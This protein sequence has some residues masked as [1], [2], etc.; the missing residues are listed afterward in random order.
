MFAE[1]EDEQG[2]VNEDERDDGLE[3]VVEQAD[4]EPNTE[5]QRLVKKLHDN[6]GHPACREMARS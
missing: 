2:L 4:L 6:L 1:D 3:P 5:E